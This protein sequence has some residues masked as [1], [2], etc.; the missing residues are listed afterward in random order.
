MISSTVVQMVGGL[1]VGT[2]IVNA[3]LAP[4]YANGCVGLLSYNSPICATTLLGLTGAA[5]VNYWIYYATLTSVI[6]WSI[7]FLKGLFK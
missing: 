7:G 3:I 1:L 5:S 2:Y 6:L 4:M